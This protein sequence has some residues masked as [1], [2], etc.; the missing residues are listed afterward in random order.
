M[1]T[2]A[3]LARTRVAAPRQ[4][5]SVRVSTLL[6]H[7]SFRPRHGVLPP[8]SI[9][10]ALTRRVE[11]PCKN[12]LADRPVRTRP[13]HPTQTRPPILCQ[14]CHPQRSS[15]G[16]SIRCIRPL[17]N[18]LWMHGVL[19]KV[20]GLKVGENGNAG[21]S[22]LSGRGRKEAF[23]DYGRFGPGRAA[24]ECWVGSVSVAG[25]IQQEREGIC[26]GNECDARYPCVRWSLSLDLH[27]GNGQPMAERGNRLDQVTREF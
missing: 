23:E 19:G 10:H 24:G 7:D 1:V 16:R 4:S 5:G 22:A 14:S 6:T 27:C 3:G 13:H 20:H 21:R 25:G 11:D 2:G 17:R 15:H 18:R 9:R 8:G 12:R 26:L